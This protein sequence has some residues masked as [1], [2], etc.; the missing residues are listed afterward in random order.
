MLKIVD[1]LDSVGVQTCE[2]TILEL[3]SLKGEPFNDLF[4]GVERCVG[5]GQRLGLR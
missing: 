4:M 5:L 1:H 2:C 3:V